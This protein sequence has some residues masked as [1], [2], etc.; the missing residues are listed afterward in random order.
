MEAECL[1]SSSSS[2]RVT[3]SILPQRLPSIRRHRPSKIMCMPLAA[4]VNKYSHCPCRLRGSNSLIFSAPSLQPQLLPELS[5]WSP[6]ARPTPEQRLPLGP[7]TSLS[8]VGPH[9][10]EVRLLCSSEL[11]QAIMNFLQQ[12]NM[13][14]GQDF[15]LLR[16]STPAQVR[17]AN[18]TSEVQVR[19]AKQ[20][21]SKSLTCKQGILMYV[22]TA[23]TYENKDSLAFFVDFAGPGNF[24]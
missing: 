9:A 1:G 3:A 23:Y 24:V 20:G 13:A 22:I 2:D 10:D 17:N 8:L 7:L 21:S 16:S 14:P 19:S 4:T 6:A 15:L 5:A 12:Q 18:G 11:R